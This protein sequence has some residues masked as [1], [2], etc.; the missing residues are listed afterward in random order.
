MELIVYGIVNSVSLILMSIGFALV[1]G[2]SRVPNFAH[3]ALFILAGYMTWVFRNQWGLPYFI[4]IL[5]ALV[6]IGIVGALLYQVILIRVRGMPISEIIASFGISL[7]ILEFLRWSGLKGGTYMLPPF[8]SGTINFLGV[9]I[10]Y[11]RIIII[12][13]GIGLLVFLWLFTTHTKTGLALK[14]IAQNERAALVLGI[15]SDVAATVAVALGA[16]FAGIAGVFLLP[17]GNITVEMGYEVLIFAIAVSVCGG[18]GSWK[19][20]VYASFLIGF[21]QI[22][23]V[24]FVAS[25]WHFVVALLVIIIVLITRPSGFFGKQKELEER[26]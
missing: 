16:V 23:T 1:Y 11:Q 10:D 9:S 22:L 7:A 14:A 21:A 25:H 20:A 17:L 18:L 2:V 13:G 12:V 15:D 24:R 6:F 5:L 26:V 4:A 8:V 19:G 3:G